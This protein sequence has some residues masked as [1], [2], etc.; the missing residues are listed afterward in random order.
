MA[1]KSRDITSSGGVFQNFSDR[2]R[3][4]LRLMGDGR[5]HALIKILPLGALSY[6]FA[7]ALAPG[8]LDDALVLWLG[9]TVFVE[10]CPPAVVEE[11]EDEIRRVLAGNWKE[12][13]G[14]EVIDGEVR[15][16]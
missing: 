4:I 6:P 13:E 12:P 16:L 2:L 3:L 15:D 7:P 10:L 8:P 5:V 11:H 9:T 14:D 1:D